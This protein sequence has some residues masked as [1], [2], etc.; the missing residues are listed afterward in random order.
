MKYID[1]VFAVI[2]AKA[3]KGNEAG[4]RIEKGL[5]GMKPRRRHRGGGQRDNVKQKEKSRGESEKDRVP[6]HQY[7]TRMRRK[8]IKN[9]N[10]NV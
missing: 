6:R 8:G 3:G 5:S 1:D 4:T 9:G 10:R 2:E 7:G